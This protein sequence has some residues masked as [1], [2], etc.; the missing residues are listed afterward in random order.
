MT[1]VKLLNISSAR[2][3]GHHIRA[4]ADRARVAYNSEGDPD[5][6]ARLM[7]SLMRRGHLKP[8]RAVRLY[9]EIELP[10]MCLWQFRTHEALDNTDYDGFVGAMRNGIE[11]SRR[12]CKD[13]F[14]FAPLPPGVEPLLAEMLQKQQEYGVSQYKV[15]LQQGVKPE[16]ARRLLADVYGLMTKI[17]FDCDLKLF[18]WGLCTERLTSAAQVET[19]IV[20]EMMFVQLREK[21]PIV[22]GAFMELRPE[23]F[24]G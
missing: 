8:F 12:Y 16:L 2:P 21:M 14:Y 23:L 15:A 1:T 3:D 6:D 7:R 5:K 24:E 10:L 4:I 9:W 11:Q 18:F 13:E 19:R 22:A 17:S 20:V